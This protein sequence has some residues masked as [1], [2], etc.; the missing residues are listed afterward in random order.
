MIE[1]VFTFALLLAV[2]EFIL[3]SMVPPRYRLR[4]LGSRVTCVTVHIG[5]LLINICVH[6]GTVTWTMSATGAFAVSY[7]HLTLPTIHVE[8]RSRWSP[9]H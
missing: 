6:W 5:M 7:T 2:F 3:L 8:C 9:Y 1:V 4:L